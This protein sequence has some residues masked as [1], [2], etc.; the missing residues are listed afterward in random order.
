MSVSI[1]LVSTISIAVNGIAYKQQRIQLD[2][3]IIECLVLIFH[4]L[5]AIIGFNSIFAMPPSSNNTIGMGISGIR[6]LVA[7]MT[8][9]FDTF[10]GQ[11]VWTI[12]INLIPAVDLIMCMA[13]LWPAHWI[14]IQQ[15]KPQQQRQRRRKQNFTTVAANQING[16]P[17][18]KF[19]KH[20][21]PRCKMFAE[22]SCR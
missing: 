22:R 11:S 20:F 9:V 18:L 5:F 6:A 10:N 1:V 16:K 19:R 13:K 15:Q 12:T 17:T 4:T 21:K 7:E 2:R 8:R 14:K 3:Q